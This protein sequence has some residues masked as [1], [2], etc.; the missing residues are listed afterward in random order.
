[1]GGT[2]VFRKPCYSVEGVVGS[3]EALCGHE[4]GLPSGGVKRNASRH[5]GQGKSVFCREG[6]LVT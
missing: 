3:G 1:V 6:E 4:L 2:G 5:R